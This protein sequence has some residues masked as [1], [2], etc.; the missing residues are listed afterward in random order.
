MIS[1]FLVD[2]SRGRYRP[3]PFLFIVRFIF[4]GYSV[5]SGQFKS[6]NM[7]AISSPYGIDGRGVVS[8]EVY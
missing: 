4:T 3:M 1:Y 7:Y 6:E 5:T 8:I 2:R